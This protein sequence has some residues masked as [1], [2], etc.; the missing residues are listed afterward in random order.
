MMVKKIYSG[1]EALV[2]DELIASSDVVINAAIPA[3]RAG[4]IIYTAGYKTA[5]QKSLDNKWISMTLGGSGGSGSTGTDG[6]DGV[7]PLLQKSTSAI[8]VSYD[9]GSTYSDLVALS[10][11]KGAKGDTGAKGATGATGAAGAKGDKGDKGDAF[12]YADFTSSQL[13][14]L[15]GE[16]GDKGDTGATGTKGETGATGA[17]GDKGD[18][19]DTGAAGANGKTPVKGTDYFTASEVQDIVNQAIA[20][21]IANGV[22]VQ[23]SESDKQFKLAVDDSGTITAVPV[24]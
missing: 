20:G 12:T 3:S 10:E 2:S 5:K 21:V 4:M 7:T 8:Q 22:I 19:G 17:K 14:A 16:K 9:N 13:A 11:L 15:K 23:S 1:E 6:K 18:K 24:E